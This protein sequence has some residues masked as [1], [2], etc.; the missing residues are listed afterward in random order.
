MSQP[1]KEKELRIIVSETRSGKVIKEK[2]GASLLWRKE[3]HNKHNFFILDVQK[4]ICKSCGHVIE[5]EEPRRVF[6][7]FG[8]LEIQTLVCEL[9]SK[10]NEYPFKEEVLNEVGVSLETKQQSSISNKKFNETIT[11]K[12]AQSHFR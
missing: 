12:N 9:C 3:L 2:L 4:M 1:V 8:K 11:R 10:V 6:V 7:E 5:L